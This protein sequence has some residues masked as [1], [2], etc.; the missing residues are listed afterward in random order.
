MPADQTPAPHLRLIAANDDPDDPAG[1]GLAPQMLDGS[2]AVPVTPERSLPRRPG[3]HLELYTF[4]DGAPLE[5]IRR[6]ARSRRIFAETAVA[7]VLE[8][9][10]VVSWLRSAGLET[11]LGALQRRSATTRAQIELWS[12]NGSYLRHLF[13]GAVDAVTGSGSTGS[14]RPLRSPRVALPVRLIDRLG[15]EAPELGGDPRAEL[16]AA[17]EWEAAALLAGETMSE[18]AY[19]SALEELSRAGQPE[20]GGHVDP[21]PVGGRRG[22]QSPGGR[23]GPQL[24]L[25][26]DLDGC[27]DDRG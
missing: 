11:L 21:L 5:P 19:R 7:L 25:G 16:E 22:G 4:S 18:W 26:P 13:T 10:M 12:A 3:D 14:E 27:L 17:V 6:A 9:A 15:E 24:E 23:E 2:A 8:R 1:P 20:L